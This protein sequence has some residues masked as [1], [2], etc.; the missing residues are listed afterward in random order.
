MVTNLLNTAN[1]E[2]AKKDAVVLSHIIEGSVLKAI[3]A[4]S[5]ALVTHT[6]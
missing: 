4:S 6:S 2:S 3:L 5:L 1:V